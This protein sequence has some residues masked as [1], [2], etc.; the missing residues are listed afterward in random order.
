MKTCSD[1]QITKPYSAFVAKV[2]C[3]DG[4]EPRCRMCRSIKYN[5]STPELVC[6][7]ILQTQAINSIKRGHPLPNYDV[8][9]LVGWLVSQP[10]FPSIYSVWKDSGYSKDLTPILDEDLPPALKVTLLLLE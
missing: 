8:K 5:K 9:L 3:K 4:F 1:C 6:K 2:S 10:Q 7:K